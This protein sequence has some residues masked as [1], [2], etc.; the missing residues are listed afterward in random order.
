MKIVIMPA[1]NKSD[2]EKVPA[3]IQ[4]GIEFKLVR[5]MKE[6]IAIAFDA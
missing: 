2:L 4:K 5:D 6:V 1:E 3:N